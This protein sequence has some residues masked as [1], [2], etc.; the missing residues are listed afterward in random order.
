MYTA[1]II[2]FPLLMIFLARHL[3]L[4]HN[5]VPYIIALNWAGVIQFL[6]SGLSVVLLYGG[7]LTTWIFAF[8]SLILMILFLLY[9]WYVARVALEASGIVAAG[10]VVVKTLLTL[11]LQE[12][13]G[14]LFGV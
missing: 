7:L 10:L 13:F 2:S 1:H 14:R 4:E 9:E 5:Y 11:V 6:I 8:A 12:G 3:R